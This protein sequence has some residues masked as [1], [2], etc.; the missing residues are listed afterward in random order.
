MLCQKAVSAHAKFIMLIC[1]FSSDRKMQSERGNYISTSF[2]S[3]GGGVFSVLCVLFRE[4]LEH[5]SADLTW[6]LTPA[7]VICNASIILIAGFHLC[8]S[9]ET[10]NPSYWGARKDLMFPPLKDR[11]VSSIPKLCKM[12]E[13]H[14]AQRLLLIY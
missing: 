10:R 6:L 14:T 9:Q 7:L 2:W 8:H 4:E 13:K 1:A 3:G 11:I 12:L 5:R